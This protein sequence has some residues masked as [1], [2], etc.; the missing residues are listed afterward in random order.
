MIDLMFSKRKLLVVIGI[1][2]AI[3]VGLSTGVFG[4]VA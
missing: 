3:L 4:V 2:V 1:A